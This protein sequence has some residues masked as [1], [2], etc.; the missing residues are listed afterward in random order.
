MAKPLRIKLSPIDYVIHCFHG[1][2]PLGRKLK[3]DPSTITRL[4]QKKDRAGNVGLIPGALQKRI[5]DL[6]HEEGLAITPDNVVHG[7]E[8]EAQRIA[9]R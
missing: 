9:Q 5:L 4:R 8:V 7:G 3:V 6:A 1:V 2:R